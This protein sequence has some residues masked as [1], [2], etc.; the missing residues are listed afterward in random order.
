[1]R[2]GKFVVGIDFDG[3][4]ANTIEKKFRES[5]KEDGPI[6][7]IGENLLFFAVDILHVG[8]ST[9]NRIAN[10]SVELNEGLKNLIIELLKEGDEVVIVT[11]NKNI[12]RIKKILLENGLDLEVLYSKRGGKNGFKFIDILLD[13]SYSEIKDKVLWEDE[14]NS[15][16][17]GILR[18]IGRRVASSAEEFKFLLREEKREKER[19]LVK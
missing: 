14:H 11:S 8:Q 1:M 12:D 5:F 2:N 9:A 16:F 6:Q 18:L 15:I 10:R 17:A 3:T 13:D 19:S 4:L 7:Q